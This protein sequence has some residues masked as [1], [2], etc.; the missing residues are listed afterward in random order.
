VRGLREIGWGPNEP[1]DDHSGQT[2][3]LSRLFGFLEDGLGRRITK[4]I[5]HRNYY[6]CHWRTVTPDSVTAE[7]LARGMGGGRDHGYRT[8][9]RVAGDA[10]RERCGLGR[11]EEPLGV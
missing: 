11:A 4:Q 2:G 9:F 8:K 5:G 7:L 3:I 10:G 6:L 1:T